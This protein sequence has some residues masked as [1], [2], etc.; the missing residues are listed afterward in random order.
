MVALAV[1]GA[2]EIVLVALAVNWIVGPR[3]PL[4][5]AAHAESKPALLVPRQRMPR[6]PHRAAPR[7]TQHPSPAPAAPRRRRGR[8]HRRPARRLRERAAG[9]P[10]LRGALSDR[11]PPRGLHLGD[12][13]L[14]ARRGA[15]TLDRGRPRARRAGR[16]ALVRVRRPPRAAAR[17]LAR[18]AC[19]GHR[20]QTLALRLL[21]GE[22]ADAMLL[23]STRA[24]SK[25]LVD[26]RFPFRSP[27]LETCLQHI[28]GR[29][30]PTTNR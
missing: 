7:R 17:G 30:S 1:H 27:T 16:G 11:R 9:A 28:L 24:N 19:G 13:L 14:A 20:V 25:R 26:E 21:L 29:T 2:S 23:A 12:E 22:M 4:E 8:C 10:G 15:R 18:D 6:P 3:P 5:R